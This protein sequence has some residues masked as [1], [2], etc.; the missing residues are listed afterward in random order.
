MATEDCREIVM[1][2]LNE[3]EHIRAV[4]EKIG[5]AGAEAARLHSCQGNTT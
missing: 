1:L 3:Y 5:T 4:V 2:R